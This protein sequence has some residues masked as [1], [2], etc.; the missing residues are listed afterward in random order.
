MQLLPPQEEI[1]R[2]LAFVSANLAS[3]LHLKVG[4]PPT[5]R[6]GGHLRRVESPELPNSEYIEQMMGALMSTAKREDYDRR[7]GADFAARAAE[8]RPVSR[9]RVPLGRRNARRAAPRAEQDPEFRGTESA[10]DLRKDDHELP[11]RPDPGRGRD[12]Q[13][14]EFDPGR[15]AQ[16]HQ[17]PSQS[18]RDHDRGSDRVCLPAAE[19]HHLAARDRHRR[20]QLS[21]SACDSSSGRIRTAS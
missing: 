6:I 19:V 3:D 7:G 8:R 10:A 21:G 17:R 2:L 20:R 5:I 12:R 11:R 15:D 4:Y 1:H 9:Q 16:V 13:R 18:A 14:Q